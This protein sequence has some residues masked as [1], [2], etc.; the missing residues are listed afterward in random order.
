MVCYKQH[1]L[2]W[3][4]SRLQSDKQKANPAP[5]C[6][7]GCCF[8]QGSDVSEPGDTGEPPLPPG[9][10]AQS[11]A[12]KLFKEHSLFT[13]SQT[14]KADK[15]RRKGTMIPISCTRSWATEGWVCV[16]SELVFGVSDTPTCLS[17]LPRHARRVL[18]PLWFPALTAQAP[19]IV[20]VQI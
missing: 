8:Q 16:C 14:G 6:C 3:D 10:G 19:R 18:M 17:C 11:F 4:L 1:L 2:R 5:W 15:G 13:S 9:P 7:T 20:F 12:Q